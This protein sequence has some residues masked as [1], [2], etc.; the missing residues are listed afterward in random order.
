[1]LPKYMA[2]PHNG[3]ERPHS[4][5]AIYLERPSEGSSGPPRRWRRWSATVGLGSIACCSRPVPRL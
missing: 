3:E 2:E 1:M 4:G 5:R